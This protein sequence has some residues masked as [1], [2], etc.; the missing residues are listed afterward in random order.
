[1]TKFAIIILIL[2]YWAHISLL[3]GQ[4]LASERGKRRF[5]TISTENL[6]SVTA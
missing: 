6:S 4:Y 2:M 1:L 3:A 5:F